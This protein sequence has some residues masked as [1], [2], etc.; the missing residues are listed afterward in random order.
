MNL[1]LFS[2]VVVVVWGDLDQWERLLSFCSR[3]GRFD[4]FVQTRVALHG[5]QAPMRRR[6]RNSFGVFE[7]LFLWKKN[8]LLAAQLL[9]QVHTRFNGNYHGSIRSLMEDWHS[10]SLSSSTH[11]QI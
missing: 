6:K 5:Y 1:Y 11:F 7:A 3:A 10:V 9:E 4:Y 2:A 8:N